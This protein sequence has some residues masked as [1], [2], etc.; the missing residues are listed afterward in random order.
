MSYLVYCIVCFSCLSQKNL[1]I[2]QIGHYFLW[3]FPNFAFKMDTQMRQEEISLQAL[4]TN[5]AVH[6]GYS[7]DDIVIVDSIQ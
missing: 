2:F 6:V 7:D 1:K 3:K 5:E 4:T